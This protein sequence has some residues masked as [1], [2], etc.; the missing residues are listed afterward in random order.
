MRP[1]RLRAGLTCLAFLAAGLPS[2]LFA[3]EA[4][5]LRPFQLVRSLEQVQDRIAA[6][7]HAALPMQHKLLEMVD[8]RFREAVPQDFEDNRNFTALLIYAM[9]GGNPV[10]LDV[11]LSRLKKED[12]HRPLGA[13]ILLYLKGQPKAA[14]IALG[15]V[16]PKALTQELGPYVALVK[17]STLATDKPQEALQQLDQARLLGPGTLVE[18]AALRRSIT[19]SAALGD[20]KRFMM[21]SSQYVRGF[22]RSP[23]ASQFADAFVAGVIALHANI[24]LEAVAEIASLMDAEREKVLYLRIA[25]RAAI[26]GMTELSAFA[27]AKAEGSNLPEDPRAALYASLAA[28]T[29]GTGGDVAARLA[30]ID[31][32]RLSKS[33]KQLLDAARA[34]A[35]GL[36]AKPLQKAEQKPITDLPP[37][38][39]AEPGEPSE[40]VRQVLAAPTNASVQQSKPASVETAPSAADAPAPA[41]DPTEIMMSETRK[42]IEDI[43]KLLGETAR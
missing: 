17:G 11:A 28:I 34:V 18:E 33:D 23:Y 39:T 31:R 35:A 38:E 1:P 4:D 3:E 13:A 42:K 36:M 5:R 10:T 9:S 27:A 37:P 24:D 12:P 19:L 26:D 14:Q 7:D 30:G 6:G 21:A 22:I 40:Q 41:A 32:D 20:S 29:S 15:E 25:R 16:D 43:D 8:A 2:S